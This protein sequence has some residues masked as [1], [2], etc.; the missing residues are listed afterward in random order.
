M[1]PPNIKF[2]T[3]KTEQQP[4]KEQQPINLALLSNTERVNEI[5]FDITCKKCIRLGGCHYDR[6]PCDYKRKM[7]KALQLLDTEQQL[8]YYRNCDTRTFDE[9]KED[10]TNI[11]NIMDN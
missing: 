6:I 2:L 9:I 8:R 3:Q 5:L 1:I 7:K 4:I 10:L 11:I